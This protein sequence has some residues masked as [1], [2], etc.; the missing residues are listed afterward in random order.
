MSETVYDLV[1]IGGGSGGSGCAKRAA[2]YG[3]KVV[4]I[5]RGPS[6]DAQG[7]RQGGGYGGTCVNVGCVPKKLMFNAAQQRENMIGHVNLAE[8]YGYKVPEKAGEFDW[9]GV[10]ARRDKY[11]ANLNAG[12]ENGWKKLGIEVVQGV[13]SFADANTVT[14]ALNSGGTQ[15]LKAKYVLVACGGKPKMQSIPG[16]ELAISSDGFFDL[17]KQPKKAAVF[18]AGYIAVELAAILHALGT[19]THLFFRGETV[20][21]HG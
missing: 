14:V 8:G 6:R 15:T 7:I 10:K 17:E 1:V 3:Q 16:A 12:Y 4:V 20:M 19:E 2:A 9:A 13:A 18:G 11:V 21:R 5:E